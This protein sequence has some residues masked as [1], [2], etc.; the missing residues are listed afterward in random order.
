[1]GRSEGIDKTILFSS[2]ISGVKSIFKHSVGKFS[3]EAQKF[4]TGTQSLETDQR[5]TITILLN[6]AQTVLGSILRHLE[7]CIDNLKPRQANNISDY[8]RT[9]QTL[10][11][12]MCDYWSLCRRYTLEIAVKSA[13]NVQTSPAPETLPEESFQVGM[14][15]QVIDE[16]PGI[17]KCLDDCLL[18]FTVAFEGA[19]GA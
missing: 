7:F 19:Q 11:V 18:D 12:K 8:L 5:K 15:S 9:I 14:L 3:R 10:L 4:M 1:M 6:N 2:I 16:F 17:V 13:T